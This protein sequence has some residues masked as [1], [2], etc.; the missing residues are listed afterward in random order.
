MS[1]QLTESQT[2]QVKAEK[3]AS[4]LRESVKSLREVWTREL[5][6]VREEWRKGEE[7]GRRE[8]DEAVR[9]FMR[10]D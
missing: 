6:G 4:S 5:K 10:I 2:S 3:E 1:A 9:L 8:R 7:Q